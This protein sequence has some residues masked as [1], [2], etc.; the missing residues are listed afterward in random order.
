[1]RTIH[2]AGRGRF[3]AKEIG[4][5][6]IRSAQVEDSRAIAEVHVASWQ[7]AYVGQLPDDYLAALSISTREADWRKSFL[8]SN[9]RILLYDHGGVIQGFVSVGPSRDSDAG[10]NTG[11]IYTIYL[12]PESQGRGVGSALWQRAIEVLRERGSTEVVVW[13]LNTN[14]V[15]RKFYEARGCSLDGASK[16]SVIGG[17]D[18]VELR[19]RYDCKADNPK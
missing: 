8:H 15:A 14:S 6:M 2:Y 12:R 3:Y 17:K 10:P 5:V 4:G 16:N 9:H 7:H 18:V 19:Y 11:E 1:V 13:A